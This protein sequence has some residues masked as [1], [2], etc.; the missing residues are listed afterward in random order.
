M[1]S[2]LSR[3]GVDQL[4]VALRAA[5]LDRIRLMKTAFLHWHRRGRPAEGPFTFRP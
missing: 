4:V 3:A 1:G 5:P 2:G